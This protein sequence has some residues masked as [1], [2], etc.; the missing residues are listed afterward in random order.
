[1][2]QF[3]I[4]L[5]SIFIASAPFGKTI[6]IVCTY[7]GSF[8]EN[9]YEELVPSTFTVRIIE[10]DYGNVQSINWSDGGICQYTK[11][12]TYNDA[13]ILL[14]GCQRPSWLEAHRSTPE[15]FFEIDRYSGSFRR[16]SSLPDTEGFLMFVGK[17]RA[18][19]QKF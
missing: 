17:C 1:M 12:A 8:D 18:G 7:E 15:G 2:K 16:Y 5:C 6:N 13:E 14:N 11:I 19:A 3:F 4:F 9:G 10:D